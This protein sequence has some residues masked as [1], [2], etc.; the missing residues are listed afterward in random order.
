M[1]EGARVGLAIAND[2]D[3]SNT[4]TI[5]MSDVSGTVVGTATQTV[6]ARSSVS[7]F[8]DELAIL[9]AN[10]YGPVIV[11]S[12]SGTG[13]ILGIRFTGSIFSIIPETIR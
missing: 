1:G 12:S 2:S 6:K 5:N 11:S 3:Q 7:K 4:Y 9:P 13:S 10:Y 8:L